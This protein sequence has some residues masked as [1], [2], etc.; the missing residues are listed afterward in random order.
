MFF[1]RFYI[2]GMASVSVATGSQH[3]RDFMLFIE[4]KWRGS[5]KGYARR[6]V[7]YTNEEN[8]DDI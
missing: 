7:H 3:D 6:G 8:V 2:Y 1:I 5:C 4:K